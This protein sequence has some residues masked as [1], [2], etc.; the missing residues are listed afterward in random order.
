MQMFT[1]IHG[2]TIVSTMNGVQKIQRK[3]ILFYFIYL[4]QFENFLHKKLVLP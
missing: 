2:W 3:F 1:V 4:L